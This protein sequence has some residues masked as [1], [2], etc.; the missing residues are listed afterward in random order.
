MGFFNCRRSRSLYLRQTGNRRRPAPEVPGKAAETMYGI[1]TDCNTSQVRILKHWE[2]EQN[3]L[4]YGGQ[5]GDD[6]KP[7]QSPANEA[8]TDPAPTRHEPSNA[9]QSVK[10]KSKYEATAVY[11]SPKGDRFS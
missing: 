3:M 1:N 8:T 7:Y 6:G 2:D 4:E 10:E 5:I 11:R 9:E